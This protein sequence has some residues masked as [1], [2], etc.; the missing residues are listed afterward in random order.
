LLVADG[1]VLPLGARLARTIPLGLQPRAEAR[2]IGRLT[3]LVGPVAR[4]GNLA[5]QV[6]VIRTLGGFDEGLG[7]DTDFPSSKHSDLVDRAIRAGLQLRFLTD[8]IVSSHSHRTLG[9]GGLQYLGQILQG[10]DRDVLR[11][12]EFSSFPF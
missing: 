7:V 10:L 4:A 12:L 5:I 8:A 9:G 1:R 3:N 11:V 2:T 6:S